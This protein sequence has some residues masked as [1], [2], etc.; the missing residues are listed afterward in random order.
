MKKTLMIVVALLVFTLPLSAYSVNSLKSIDKKSLRSEMVAQS[1]TVIQKNQRQWHKEIFDSKVKVVHSAG[2]TDEFNTTSLTLDQLQNHNQS[3]IKGTVYNLQKMNSP[4]NM[5]YTKAKIHVDKVIS[6]DKTMQGKNIY[7]VFDGGLVS[8]N[9]WYTK[10]QSK[11]AERE[12]FVK[13]DEFPLP[14]IGSKIITGLIPNHLDEPSDHNAVLKQSGF[15]IHNSYTIS[16]PKYNL[17]IK[18]TS[19][20]E[21][22]LNNPKLKE[23]TNNPL[24]RKLQSL[25]KQLNQKYNK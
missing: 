2:F 9:H 10:E 1:A 6:G 3:V 7:L 15:T 22:Q 11:N 12:L 8:F 5:A 17:W 13:N 4:K 16:N 23:K 21:F 19:A 18:N 14:A 20:K 25:T 24:I